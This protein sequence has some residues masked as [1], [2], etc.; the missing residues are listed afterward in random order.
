[1][2]GPMSDRSDAVLLD[3]LLGPLTTALRE[4][5]LPLHI[6]LENRFGE[7]NENQAEMIEAARMSR[8]ILDQPA[9]DAYRGEPVFPERRISSD[10]E[11]TDFIRRKA[12]SIYHPVGTCRM[13][14]DDRAVVDSELRVRG[15][16]GLRVVDASVM[17]SLPTG[18]T[19]A[20]TIMI[21]ERASALIL[22]K[23]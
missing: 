18:N 23:G 20:P 10:A 6:L 7:L 8:E 17:P 4:I 9:F 11:Y 3:A 16:P 13:G 21:A 14:T 12:E 19:N 5:G 2:T 1:M 22:G 15:V